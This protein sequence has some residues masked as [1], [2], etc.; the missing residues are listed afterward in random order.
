MDWEDVL[1]ITLALY[2]V[3]M[4]FMATPIALVL[5]LFNIIDATTLGWFVLFFIGGIALIG[6]AAL[7]LATLQ[8]GRE[9]LTKAVKGIVSFYASFG[10]VMVAFYASTSNPSKYTVVSLLVLWLVCLALYFYMEEL[11]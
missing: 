5:Y 3:A 10:P 4:S 9:A 7:V 2:I 11:E 8:V 6:G 1:V